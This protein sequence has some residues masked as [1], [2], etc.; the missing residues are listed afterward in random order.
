M[1][2]WWLMGRVLASKKSC[3]RAITQWH[4]GIRNFQT[5]YDVQ[6]PSDVDVDVEAYNPARSSSCQCRLQAL[7]NARMSLVVSSLATIAKMTSSGNCSS[8]LFC[9]TGCL[10]CHWLSEPT[11]AEYKSLSPISTQTSVTHPLHAQDILSLQSKIELWALHVPCSMSELIIIITYMLI[12]ALILIPVT[13]RMYDN[14]YYHT[15]S[16]SMISHCLPSSV[17]MKSHCLPR[18]RVLVRDAIQKQHPQPD[19]WV[20]NV[21]H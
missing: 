7:L 16:V 8:R 1:A 4:K 17:S 2:C 21:L 20:W 12:W 13:C 15:R 14:T 9:W 11:N 18:L 6:T 3:C 5:K 10:I 19:A